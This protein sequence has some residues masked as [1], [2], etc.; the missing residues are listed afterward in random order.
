[1]MLCELLGTSVSPQAGS[2]V[3]EASLRVERLIAEILT[4][5]TEIYAAGKAKAPGGADGKKQFSS[6]SQSPLSMLGAEKD[7][8]H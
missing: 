4:G 7:M 2:F 3:V 8:N 1:M 6:A 5:Q